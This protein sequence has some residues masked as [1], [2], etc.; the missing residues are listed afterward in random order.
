MVSITYSAKKISLLF[1]CAYRPPR[2]VS[3]YEFF[4]TLSFF[5]KKFQNLIIVGDFNGHLKSNCSDAVDFSNCCDALKLD[6][7]NTGPSFHQGKN[8]SWLDVVVVVDHNKVINIHKSDTS[9]ID[10]HDSFI[11]TYSIKMEKIKNTPITY[12][13]FKK[14]NRQN[15]N[16]D[17]KIVLA[18]HFDD[19]NSTNSTEVLHALN[20]DLLLVLDKHAA[21]TTFIPKP[22]YNPW[23]Q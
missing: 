20:S 7:V 8:T 3:F 1:V 13:N 21:L 9:F 23:T 6:I 19:L 4:K 15:Y 12:R 18:K 22:S 14:C 16:E 5:S 11:V 17:V 2:G 10:F